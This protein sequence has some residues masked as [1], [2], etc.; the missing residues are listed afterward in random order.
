[1]HRAGWYTGDSLFDEFLE[2]ALCPKYLFYSYF[3]HWTSIN[4]DSLQWMDSQHG[5]LRDWR[6]NN[7][8]EMSIELLLTG[9]EL[10]TRDAAVIRMELT[11]WWRS[12]SGSNMQIRGA[13]R[14]NLT[15]RQWRGS[16]EEISD[17]GL[18]SCSLS[19]SFL[20]CVNRG[21]QF[22]RTL[23]WAW[24]HCLGPVDVGRL[25]RRE[26]ESLFQHWASAVSQFCLGWPL[27]EQVGLAGWPW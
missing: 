12:W 18:C 2:V 20:S 22:M 25:L 11:A 7:F 10:R 8:Q 9:T 5:S 23:P 26:V 6:S 3:F 19:N 13:L 4:R 1:M 15:P 24:G 16:Q 17:P 14:G 21:S 27:A